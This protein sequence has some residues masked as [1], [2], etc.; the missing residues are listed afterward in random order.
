METRAVH[1][2]AKESHLTLK[3]LELRVPD[4]DPDRNPEAVLEV[5]HGRDHDHNHDHNHDHDQGHR[6][7]PDPD[8]AQAQSLGAPRDRV[9]R[10]DRDQARQR[11]GHVR[12]RALDRDQDQGRVSR[13]QGRLVDREKVA[14]RQDQGQDLELVDQGRPVVQEKLRQGLGQEVVRDQVE[15]NVDQGAKVDRNL[16]LFQGQDHDRVHE[17]AVPVDRQGK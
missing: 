17:V 4:H 15:K 14:R 11:A 6:L 1:E 13:V 12:D 16:N 5:V 2:E 9:V 10:L 8:L 3:N 7:V